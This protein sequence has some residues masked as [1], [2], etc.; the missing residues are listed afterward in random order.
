MLLFDTVRKVMRY[1]PEMEGLGVEK[2]EEKMKLC[3]KLG[4]LCCSV[5]AYFAAIRYYEQQVNNLFY[6]HVFILDLCIYM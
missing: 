6:N 1:S 5:K 4:D 3:E 2:A